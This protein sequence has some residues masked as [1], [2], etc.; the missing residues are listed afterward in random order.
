MDTA[1]LKVFMMKYIRCDV[2]VIIIFTTTKI[3]D[4]EA[5]RVSYNNCN[6][7]NYVTDYK[8]KSLTFVFGVNTYS[9]M[10]FENT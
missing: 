8:I 4:D 6:Q 1:S 5:L 2:Y 7:L 3:D 10:N 9:K